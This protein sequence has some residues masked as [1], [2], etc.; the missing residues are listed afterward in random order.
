MRITAGAAAAA[1]AAGVGIGG[2]GGSNT[3]SGPVVNVA[4][5]AVSSCTVSGTGGGAVTVA[6]TATNP[7]AY[8]I[9][10]PAGYQLT[11]EVD[12]PNGG[13]TSGSSGIGIYPTTSAGGEQNVTVAAGATVTLTAQGE[14][15]GQIPTA[16][17]IS[18][19]G[20]TP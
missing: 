17:K 2:C 14:W 20:Y 16:C 18:T 15:S 11:A 7:A 3:G 1:L 8:A 6:A 5:L 19:A 13:W 9:T 10:L 4:G 12:L